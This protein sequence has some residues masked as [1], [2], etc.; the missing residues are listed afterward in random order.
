MLPRRR[1]PATLP[2]SPMGQRAPRRLGRATSRTAVLAHASGAV[3]AL[4]G[5]DSAHGLS[6]S[7]VGRVLD[8]RQ[9]NAHSTL[10]GLE[11]LGQLERVPGE[12]PVRWRRAHA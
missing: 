4:G 7:E 3:L 1:R 2:R 12:R 10:T 8:I 6:A 11:K 5:L 9:Q